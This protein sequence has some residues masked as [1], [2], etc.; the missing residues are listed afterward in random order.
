MLCSLYDGLVPMVILKLSGVVGNFWSEGVHDH[1]YAFVIFVSEGIFTNFSDLGQLALSIRCGFI[2]VT[3]AILH[4]HFIYRYLVLNRSIFIQKYF[5]PYG[6]I[7]TFFYCFLHMMLWTAVCEF[8]FYG[9]HERK[10]Y[11]HDS[12]KQLY[13][14]TSYDFNM[15]IAL[16][17]EGSNEAVIRS[18]IGVAVVSTSSTYSM[19]LFF[20]L[21]HKIVKNL[22]S[23]S[24]ISAKTLRLQHQ[25]FKALTVQ[26]LIPICVSL[27]PCMAVWFGPVFLLDFRA[28]Y[29]AATI[30]ASAFPC[31]D[32]VAI[33]FF[34]PC[35]RKRLYFIGSGP[36]MSSTTHPNSS[37]RIS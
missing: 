33:V 13:N 24:N 17:W 7:L 12:F 20:V 30:A 37:F 4:A 2:T 14:L 19:G 23:H 34:L 15:V 10:E 11:I 35:L 26:T 27:M 36:S 8:F 32:P 21:G 29:L 18:W 31:I 25:L 28:I 9:D 3:Y 5:M 6:L 16:Y 22:K 1:R